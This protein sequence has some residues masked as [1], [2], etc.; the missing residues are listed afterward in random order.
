MSRPLISA[1]M[2][3]PSPASAEYARI[4]VFVESN[5]HGCA[6]AGCRR[7]Q[8]ASPP[9]HGLD[10][11]IR[12][13]AVAGELADLSAHGNDQERCAFEDCYGI[14]CLQF[15]ARG[16]PLAD[17]DVIGLQKLGSPS[18]AGSPVAVVVPVNLGGHLCFSVQSDPTLQR[19]A[20]RANPIP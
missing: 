13:Q 19:R 1:S 8:V 16:N 20:L 15:P 6:D 18:T 4:N 14:R 17:L 9:E 12:R 2:A 7:P 5:Q 10:G 11:V 3:I